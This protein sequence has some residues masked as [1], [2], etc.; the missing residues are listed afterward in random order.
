MTQQLS[1]L[2]SQITENVVSNNLRVA[3]QKLASDAASDPLIKVST[4]FQQYA[5]T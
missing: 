3:F 4:Y 1:F 2:S 5:Y